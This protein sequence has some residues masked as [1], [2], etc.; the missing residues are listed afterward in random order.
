MSVMYDKRK[1]LIQKEG[2]NF[3]FNPK[4]CMQCQ[5]KC[6]NG[7]SGN[8]FVN[9]KEIKAISR[10][11]G[12]E[13][14]RF[15]EEYLIKVSYKFSLREIKANKDYTCIFFDNRKNRCSIYP[16]RPNQCRTFPFWAYFKDKPEEVAR[17]CPGV[18]LCEAE[19][20]EA[21]CRAHIK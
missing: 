4:A 2:F 8:I 5:G 15:I 19:Q 3:R 13:I 7:D 9:S 10:F 16:V 17:E 20:R 1:K 14:S 11:L 12:I 21:Q 6:C 18:S